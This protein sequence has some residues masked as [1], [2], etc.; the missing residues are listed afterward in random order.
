M[1]TKNFC[2][3]ELLKIQSIYIH[4]KSF[5]YCTMPNLVH[6]FNAIKCNKTGGN[7][8]FTENRF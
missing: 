7:M 3:I 5:I 8:I 4:K 1:K 6:I 2:F